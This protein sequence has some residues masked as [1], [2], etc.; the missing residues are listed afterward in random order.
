MPTW[1]SREPSRWSGIFIGSDNVFADLGLPDPEERL[2]KAKLTARVQSLLDER[3]L[4]D[5]QAAECF[6]TPALAV[7]Q[8][9]DGNLADVPITQLI[10]CLNRLGRRL[11]VRISAEEYPLEDATLT[12]IAA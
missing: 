9:L 4:T 3:G 6:D 10:K 11:E 12:V 1:M 7:S 8:M 2:L 5:E